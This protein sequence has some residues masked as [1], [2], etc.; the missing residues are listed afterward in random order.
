MIWGLGG[1]TLRLLELGFGVSCTDYI[2]GG[3][4]RDESPTRDLRSM[5]SRR[6]TIP[7]ANRTVIVDTMLHGTKWP[8]TIAGEVEELGLIPGRAYLT[9]RWS[10]FSC[11]IGLV[12]SGEPYDQ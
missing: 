7:V 1:F 4:E 12:K 6:N 11:Q 8:F 9:C 2:V 10:L 3:S 5:H